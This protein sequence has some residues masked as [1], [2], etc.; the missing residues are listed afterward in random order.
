MLELIV[1]GS[2]LC[3]LLI[4]HAVNTFPFANN[5]MGGTGEKKND[6]IALSP[7]MKSISFEIFGRDEDTSEGKTTSAAKERKKNTLPNESLKSITPTLLT[8]KGFFKQ[9]QQ[10][11]LPRDDEKH[12]PIIMTTKK[13]STAV[14][15]TPCE[16]DVYSFRLV[17]ISLNIMIDDD[18][19]DDDVDDSNI[20]DNE[21][22]DDN[23]YKASEKDPK[24][25]TLVKPLPLLQ[26]LPTRTR[27]TRTTTTQSFMDQAQIRYKDVTK[28]CVQVFSKSHHKHHKEFCPVIAQHCDHPKYME[29][30]SK[31]L[32]FKPVMQ[33]LDDNG[34]LDKDSIMKNKQNEI[35]YIPSTTVVTIADSKLRRSF[36]LINKKDRSAPTKTPTIT[37]SAQ[38]RF[39]T[40]NVKST[41]DHISKKTSSTDPTT[42]IQLASA[43][44]TQS[45]QT[46]FSMI[47]GKYETK[48]HPVLK[49]ESNPIS[50]N[51]STTSTTDPFTSTN[52]LSTISTTNYVGESAATCN[53]PCNWM[54]TTNGAVVRVCRFHY[55]RRQYC[56]DYDMYHI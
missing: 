44:N 32:N 34:A 41:P 56:E 11:N 33:V 7:S 53:Y 29:I 39:Y 36:M 19:D 18:D 47:N 54:L 27:T 31:L 2:I 21:N 43:T 4:N 24:R 3:I 40:D 12:P 1:R 8:T 38:T 5:R 20:G 37:L 51:P 25:I 42:F 55:R 6:E 9:L 28:K 26:V 16:K 30:C 46:I 52:L 22:V 48:N 50:E 15:N 35:D 13:K 17:D 49:G 10:Q 14:I 45:A 23:N